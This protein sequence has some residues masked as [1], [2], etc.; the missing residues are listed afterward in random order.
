M[1]TPRHVRATD[2]TP[3]SVGG[4]T[5]NTLEQEDP[6]NTRV[7]A[8]KDDNLDTLEDNPENWPA[9]KV[10]AAA[11]M[12]QREDKATQDRVASQQNA[13]AFVA[14]CPEYIDTKVNGQ[15]LFNQARTMFGDGVIAIP[16]FQEAY[17]HLR[18]NTN[19]LKLN[20]AEVEKRLKVDAKARFDAAQNPVT[21]SEQDLYDMPLDDL[22]RLDA[23]DAHN[24]MQ[25]RGEEGGW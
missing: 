9:E 8:F 4:F 6:F 5:R 11:E 25:R 19:F 17:E 3:M 10:K 14:G 18:N 13:D 21:P 16:Q 15:L 1:A 7:R 23:I 22:R 2:R 20:Q 24:R 12:F